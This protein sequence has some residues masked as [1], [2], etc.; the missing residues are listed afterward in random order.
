[1]LTTIRGRKGLCSE[2]NEKPSPLS[3]KMA[4]Y[5]AFSRSWSDKVADFVVQSRRLCPTISPTLS[6]NLADFVRWNSLF[7]FAANGSRHYHLTPSTV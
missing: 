6:Y 7:D 1:M 4:S 3:R 5:V 2:Q